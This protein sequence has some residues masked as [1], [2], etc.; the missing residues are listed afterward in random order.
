LN[1]PIWVFILEDMAGLS[2]LCCTE[3][4][5]TELLFAFVL[6]LLFGS[7]LSHL[8]VCLALLPL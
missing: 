5:L 8:A 4:L 3:K 1:D 6:D 2:Q 7:P